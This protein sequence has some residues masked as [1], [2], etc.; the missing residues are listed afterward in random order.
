M[1]PAE[2]LIRD[3]AERSPIL[4]VV[5]DEVL[6][7]LAI[8]EHLRECGFTVVEAVSS[9]EAIAVM[10]SGVEV[11]L[12]FSDVQ[13]P[14]EMDGVGLAQWLAVHYPEL[15]VVLTSGAASAMS[16][17]KAACAQVRF[18]VAKPYDHAVLTG[19]FH[20]LLARRAKLS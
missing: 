10:L 20:E 4:L 13:M 2:D 9:E 12:V 14:G 18:M 19:R 15:P 5:E 1:S 7:R 11:D 8:A 3:M 6:I 17:A 16:M